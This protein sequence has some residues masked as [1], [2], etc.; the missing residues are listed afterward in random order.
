M[1]PEHASLP[2]AMPEGEVEQQLIAFPPAKATAASASTSPKEQAI[3]RFKNVLIKILTMLVTSIVAHISRSLSRQANSANAIV[4]SGAS[5]TY[6][7]RA[8]RLMNAIRGSGTVTVANGKAEPVVEE[9]ELGPI[10]GAQK[11]NSFH[12]T[13][14]SVMDLLEQFGWVIFDEHG[15]SLLT[16]SE[17]GPNLLT[18][19]GR[20]NSARL[21]DLDMTA[22][23]TN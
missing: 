11:V 8:Q 21:F 20:R 13:L 17:S 1:L 5:R 18:R 2:T 6:V 23:P 14:I 15:V 19:I 7:G 4:D 3:M 9:G 16:Q 22:A 12:R 10:R